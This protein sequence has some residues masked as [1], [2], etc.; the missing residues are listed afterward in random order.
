MHDIPCYA[1][2]CRNTQKMKKIICIVLILTT[3]TAFAQQPGN[4]IKGTWKN[5]DGTARITIS[6]APN[7]YQGVISWLASP[8]GTDGKPKLDKN[9]PD[10]KLRSRPVLGIQFI[11]GLQYHNG[12]WINGKLYSP[13][14]G[15][16]AKCEIDLKD[17]DHLEM[18]VK[19][20]FFSIVKEWKRYE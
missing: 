16:Y 6:E 11:S 7:G 10:K 18:I 8:N 15:I 19:R 1:F 2:L 12:K 17:S 20:S 4:R 9:N 13:Q 3:G 5:D 14:K